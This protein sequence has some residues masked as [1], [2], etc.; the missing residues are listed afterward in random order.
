M[1]LLIFNATFHLVI[2]NLFI[3]IVPRLHKV[4]VNIK[5]ALFFLIQLNENC[6]VQTFHHLTFIHPTVNHGHL[7]TKRLITYRKNLITQT[8]NHAKKK[9]VIMTLFI[10]LIELGLGLG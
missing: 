5:I 8:L 9:K 10:Y 2:S 6:G 7:I 1:F 4:I 3:H